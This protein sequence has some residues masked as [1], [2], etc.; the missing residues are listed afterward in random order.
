M[1]GVSGRVQFDEVG[2]AVGKFSVRQ[3]IH[4]R[5]PRYMEV[6]EWRPL[7]DS[8]QQL[9]MY[10]HLTTWAGQAAPPE[11]VCSKPCGVHQYV[12]PTD[13]ACCW[14]CRACRDNEVV[15]AN[16]TGCTACPALTWPDT[17]NQT[18]CF[19]VL[20]VYVHPAMPIGLLLTTLALLGLG[21]TLAIT[22][23]YYTH[24]KE[25]LIRASSRE[26]SGVVLL[27]L[28]LEQVRDL[29]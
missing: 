3:F 4:D 28:G 17:P 21:A 2:D 1:P 22:V 10:E 12:V 6:G 16:L 25:R 26:L 8:G 29:G 5:M 23:W 27:G 15:T 14:T 9:T 13:T 19:P 20:P 11:S 18:V 7:T 24:S